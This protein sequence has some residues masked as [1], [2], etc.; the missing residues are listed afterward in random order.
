MR[1]FGAAFTPLSLKAPC[2]TAAGA[3]R[4]PP[5]TLSQR[6]PVVKLQMN[7]ETQKR[8]PVDGV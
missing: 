8:F 4:S 3:L 7:L 6:S 5:C 1:D 2:H